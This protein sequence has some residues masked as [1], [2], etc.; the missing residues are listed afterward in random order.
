M[1]TIA[2]TA[3][4]SSDIE[5]MKAIGSTSMTLDA[6]C[7]RRVPHEE[8]RA[9]CGIKYKSDHL[10]GL[11]FPFLDPDDDR[12]LAWAVRRDH[13]EVEPDGKPIAKYLA[14]PDRRHLYFGP[15]Y[16]L[17][18]QLPSGKHPTAAVSTPE[19]VDALVRRRPLKTRRRSAAVTRPSRDP[20]AAVA[21]TTPAT[22]KPPTVRSHPP[23]RSRNK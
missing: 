11:A 12:V 23:I 21:H 22:S 18:S 20:S 6:A 4:T 2:K 10:E 9:L 14:S 5:A 15:G 19:F 3:L 17:M 7:V 13:P 1:T 16:D 8:A